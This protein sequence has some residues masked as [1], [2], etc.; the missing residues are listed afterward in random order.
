MVAVASRKQDRGP[1]GRVESR[2]K[3]VHI[4]SEPRYCVKGEPRIAFD[5]DIKA[6]LL[7]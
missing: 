2:E 5:L 4:G 6:H 1:D 3:A 7:S